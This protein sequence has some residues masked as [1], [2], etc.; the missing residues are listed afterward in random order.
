MIGV[1]AGA[2]S[3]AWA[4]A[5]DGVFA[6]GIGGC[7]LH[8]GVR[9][10]GHLHV[11]G[12]GTIDGHMDGHLLDL[13]DVDGVGLLDGHGV[14]LGHLNGHWTIDGHMDGHLLVT[15]NL[16][17][18]WHW[19]GHLHVLLDG[20][21]NLADHLIGLWHGHLNLNGHALLV[22]NGVGTINMNG[23]G[24]ALGHNDGLLNLSLFADHIGSGHGMRLHGNGG[25]AVAI[26]DAASA[27]SH[28]NGSWTRV[29]N[30][31]DAITA[32]DKGAVT[33]VANVQTSMTVAIA[34]IEQ[35]AFVQLL[36]QWHL[37]GGTGGSHQKSG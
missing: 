15:D 24:H 9:N 17:G 32:A 34:Q 31:A 8:H 30:G 20:N 11:D 4:V 18:L 33:D 12:V 7:V 37:I 35:A 6:D 21:G 3:A 22:H 10:M 36:L 27:G 16:V 1:N 26:R 19:D 14:G 2:E 29:S 13:L 23:H 28:S 5:G 25:C